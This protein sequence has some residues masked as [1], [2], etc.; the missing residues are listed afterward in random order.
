MGTDFYCDSAQAALDLCK[1][2][3]WE[4]KATLFRGQKRDWPK[5]LPS[6]LRSG[7]DVNK[8]EQNLRA[9]SEWANSIPQMAVYRGSSE[10]I[11]AIAQHYG[12]PTSF[13]DLTSSPEIACMFAKGSDDLECG[14]RAVIYCFREYDLRRLEG[15]KII[16]VSVA[17]LWRLESQKG[18]FLDYLEP[19]VC[20]AIRNLA[21]KIHFPIEQ[22]TD[23]E[24]LYLYTI[25]KSALETVIDQ[26]IYRHS[27]ESA[28][29]SL[30]IPRRISIKRYTYPGAFRW[31]DVPAYEQEWIYGEEG[32]I[33]PP[34]ESISVADNHE[35]VIIPTFEMADPLIAQQAV[36]N[37][38]SNAVEKYRGSDKLLCFA[39]ELLPDKDGLN[40]SMS[41]LINRCWDG[42][43]VLPYTNEEIINSLSLTAAFVCA[44]AA[45]VQGVDEWPKKIWGEIELLD[46]APAG[47]HLEAAYVSSSSLRDSLS[48]KHLERL[49][50]WMRK[51]AID[52]PLSIMNY[53]VDPWVLFE[54]GSFRKM[55]V[56]Q[57][58]PTAVH[59]LWSEDLLESGGTL[60]CM[61][62]LS[63]NPAL[64]GFVTRSDFRFNSPIAL[65]SDVARTIYISPSM[66]RED[67]EEVFVSC[68]PEILEKSMP[69]ELKFTDYSGDSRELWEI[70]RV[71]E[72]AGY[73]MEV[74]GISVLEVFTSVRDENDRPIRGSR[75]IVRQEGIGGG[76]GAFEVWLF[77]TQQYKQV[78][79]AALNRELCENFLPTLLASN[80]KLEEL[81]RSIP[82]WPGPTPHDAA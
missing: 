75:E 41:N 50:R 60:E 77:A 30:A 12:I 2:L 55:F 24:L 35:T 61:W 38:I 40:R 44:R 80:S 47:G 3:V 66:D 52:D 53:V 46:I 79:G 62:S 23:A 25:R 5:L 4:G 58:V 63:F 10:A 11:T 43:R 33:V 21:I 70:D 20:D 45:G 27:V 14:N 65:E 22:V 1:K 64:L 18:L 76:L 15:A 74:G 9:F 49:T 68:M 39:V 71:I 54:F 78:K 48:S 7:S 28:L 37:L 29:Q 6:L 72:Q 8:S 56:E 82:D 36:S 32:W 34:I 19:G 26:W 57:F 16:R 42:L 17:N 13:L 73:I 51:A 81:A 59:S 67:I 31:R 69:F